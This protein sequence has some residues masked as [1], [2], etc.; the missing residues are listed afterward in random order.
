MVEQEWRTLD[1]AGKN[2]WRVKGIILFGLLWMFF[3]LATLLG[4]YYTPASSPEKD[5]PLWVFSIG[6]VILV[7]FF[8]VY[9]I[10][11]LMYFSRYRYAL[12]DEGIFIHR[13]IWWKYKRTIP[14]ARPWPCM[15]PAP[16]E[17]PAFSA[18]EE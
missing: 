15:G 11:V 8:I 13:G 16:S 5:I 10:W 6:T 7:S 3:A 4:W 1:A 14:Y 18:Q 12:G 17:S 9:N 2:V